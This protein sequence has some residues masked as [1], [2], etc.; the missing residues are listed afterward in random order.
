MAERGQ[1]IIQNYFI[2]NFMDSFGAQEFLFR[3]IKEL[4]PSHISLV[5]VVAE[6]LHTSPD[7]AYRRISGETPI[8]LEE[9]KELCRHYKI[10]LDQL[11]DVQSHSVLFQNIRIN[12]H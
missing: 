12:I 9:V 8:V 1:L 4:L 3:R 10:S 7:S 6:T 5:D 11:L 2:Q